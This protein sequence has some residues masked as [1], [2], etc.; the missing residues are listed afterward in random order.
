MKVSKELMRRAR[1]N[2][3]GFRGH[4]QQVRLNCGLAGIPH[5]NVVDYVYY[6][7]GRSHP[8]GCSFP[9]ILPDII[10]HAIKFV[11]TIPYAS[12]FLLGVE[13]FRGESPRDSVRRIALGPCESL[14]PYED[15]VRVARY[16]QSL[17]KK[18]DG[19]SSTVFEIY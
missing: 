15:V 10:D 12:L 17:T 18:G 11:K 5:E 6:N 8:E 16:N 3:E 13:K 1:S 19:D 7:N 4:I 2:P 9:E 14:P